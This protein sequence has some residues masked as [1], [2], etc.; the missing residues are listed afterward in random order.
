MAWSAQQALEAANG[1]IIIMA[2]NGTEVLL[3]VTIIAPHAAEMIGEAAL[4]L[5]MGATLTDLAETIHPHPSLSEALGESAEVALAKAIH[6][7]LP[8]QIN[9]VNL[10]FRPKYICLIAAI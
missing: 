8:T 1:T 9:S 3:G 4:A 2:E 5:E 10:D 7:L 6:V